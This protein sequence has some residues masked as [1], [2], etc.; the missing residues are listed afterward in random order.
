MEKPRLSPQAQRIYRVLLEK[1]EMDAGEVGKAL[2]IFSQAVYREA[3][4]LQV[5]GLVTETRQWPARF[6]A[7]RTTEAVYFYLQKEREWFFEAFGGGS[8]S[9][10]R[11]QIGALEI[12]FIQTRQESYERFTKDLAHAQRTARLLVSGLEVPAEQILAY[13]Q[14]VDRGVKISLL[15][16]QE[17][18]TNKE[19]LRNWQR[20]GI[21]VRSTKTIDARVFLIDDRIGY[22][23]SYNVLKPNQAIGVRFTY[24]PI[25]FLLS[26]LFE[27]RWK[28]A[29][30]V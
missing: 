9:D 27:N 29:N 4:Q 14:A 12:S 17:G 26:D 13:K 15:V 6:R 24:P 18:L 10:S 21:A 20:L 19:M 30:K 25:T 1:G 5:L 3:R 22:L 28:T 7:R 2:G 11:R 16:Q 8:K 23:L